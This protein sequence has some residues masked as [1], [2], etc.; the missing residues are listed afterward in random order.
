MR[1]APD[2][3]KTWVNVWPVGTGDLDVDAIQTT[4]NEVMILLAMLNGGRFI[5]E[6]LDSFESQTHNAWRLVVSDDGSVDSGPDQIEAWSRLHPSRNVTLVAGP[7]AGFARNF[8]HLLAHAD[9]STRFV[10]F[11]DQDDVWLPDKLARATAALAGVPESQPALYCGSTWI[12]DHRLSGRKVS[13]RWAYPPS[14]RNALVQN[15]APGNTIMLNRAAV[16]LLQAATRRAGEVPA[17]DWWA[18]QVIAG[19][20]GHII[21]DK[22]PSLLYRQHGTNVIGANVGL[23]AHLRRY[24]IVLRGHLRRWNDLNIDA[25]TRALPYLTPE[26]RQLVEDFAKARRAPILSR[27]RRLHRLGIHRQSRIGT[28]LLWVAAVIG[29]L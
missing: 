8:L 6:Q 12:C 10:A 3:L 25:L 14:F 9:R 17:H 20:G 16:R 5:T 21:Q 28:G 2:D 11:S 24:W 1:H 4:D 19:A 22:T 13:E 29:C 18:Y 15:I 27:P 26:N 7:Q 23:R